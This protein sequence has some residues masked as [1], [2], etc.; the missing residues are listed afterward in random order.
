MA[1]T[2]RLLDFVSITEIFRKPL[3]AWFMSR[4]NAF[5]LD[6]SRV[7]SG[8]TRIILDR[9]KRGRTIV[10]FPEGNIRTAA[11]SKK[12]KSTDA[13]LRQAQA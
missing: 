13:K 8:T 11:T 6:R 5:P 3:V 1:S 4:M 2:S 7:D 12:S 10:M 9:L